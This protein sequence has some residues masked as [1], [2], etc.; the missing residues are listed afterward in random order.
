MSTTWD[1]VAEATAEYDSL[2]AEELRLK[3]R[4]HSVLKKVV[5]AQ[6][7]DLDQAERTVASALFVEQ[8]LGEYVPGPAE[9]VSLTNNVALLGHLEQV[10]P[11]PAGWNTVHVPGMGGLHKLI[12]AM[13]DAEVARTRRNQG[14]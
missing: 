8:V 1:E 12:A 4:I 3:E 10:D 14:E 2:V 6:P 11:S 9:K 7:D 13:E 5:A